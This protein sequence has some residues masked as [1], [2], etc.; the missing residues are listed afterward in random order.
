VSFL[1]RLL[2][3]SDG[4]SDGGSAR[5]AGSRLDDRSMRP[6]GAPG[7]APRA[8]ASGEALPDEP[9]ALIADLAEDERARER[10]L[11]REEAERLDELQQRQLRFAAYAWKPADQ[12]GDRR[13]DDTDSDD[14]PSGS[15][16]M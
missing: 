2:V 15:A 11:A 1:R 7:A 3:G 5:G 14:S 12:G 10:E 13:A 6:D 4:G 16:R 9:A 8:D